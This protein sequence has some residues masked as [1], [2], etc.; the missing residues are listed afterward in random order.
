[1]DSL[2]RALGICP[3][4]VVAFVGGG[5]KT[6]LAL[7]C[8]RELTAAGRRALFTTTT[9]ILPPAGV[10]L[11][12]AAADPD[13]PAAA[14][15]HLDAGRP[16]CV[17]AAR[18]EDGKLAGLDPDALAALQAG[19]EPDVLLI[20]ADGSAQLP[21]KAPA[22]HEPVIPASA[23]L[24]VAVAGLG[25]IAKPLSAGQ[26]HRPERLQALAEAAGL[27]KWVVTPTLVAAAL[28]HPELGCAR[29]S[30]P[31]ARQVAVLN[32]ADAVPGMVAVGTAQAVLHFGAHR[33][34]LTAARSPQPVRAVAGPVAGLLLA[35]GSA[36]RFG[37]PKQLA[38]L[39]GR[40]LLTHALAAFCR[41]GLAPL[42]AVTGA[43]AAAVAA[44]LAPWPV[45]VVHN[46]DHATGMGSSFVAGFRALLEPQ[47]PGGQPERGP[48][49]ASRAEPG[50]PAGW[51]EPQAALVALG[52]MP[53]LTPA[54]LDRLVAAHLQGSAAIT[55]PVA[56]GERRNPVL[57]GRSLWPEL[58][59]VSGDEGGRSVLRRHQEATQLVPFD[60]PALFLD[61]DTP[62]DLGQA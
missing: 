50:P 44:L 48:A 53:N 11:V 34:V 28:T 18:R 57:L 1:M 27:G 47:V 45:R 26:V 31:G 17:V 13:W 8:L 9:R 3:G 52:D 41:A 61:I 23:T 20:E 15:A 46:P 62:A 58:L 49:A 42:L 51:P 6:A 38:D 10:P 54:A 19:A 55:A 60:D 12:V 59:T 56:G 32:Q 43:E 37:A 29:G 4:D 30:P 5:G 2:W 22:E 36:R 35:A 14:R 24:V 21:L 16:C 25:V 7:T 33:V 40:P 39:R